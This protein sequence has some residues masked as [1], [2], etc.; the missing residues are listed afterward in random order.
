MRVLTAYADGTRVGYTMNG[1]AAELS[2][3]EIGALAAYYASLPVSRND[4]QVDTASAEHGQTVATNGIMTAGVPSCVSCH[5][6]TGSGI[7]ATFPRI[8][9]QLPDY[10]AARIDLW[11]SGEDRADT[12]VEA[13]MARIAT[14]APPDAMSAAIA[15]FAGLDPA[16]APSTGY[17]SF[18]TNWPAQTYSTKPLPDGIDWSQVDKA[19]AAQQKRLADPT[20]YEHVP[21]DPS[22]IPKS[23]L[24][25]MI[26][27]GKTIFTDTQVLRGTFVGNDL[28]CSN[29]H[30]NAG[31]NPVAAPIWATAVDF[32]VYRGK[33]QH[34][35]TLP[36]RLAGCFKFSMNGTAPPA[37]HEVMVALE[38]YMKWLATGAPSGAVQ[39]ARGYI[40]LP[41]PAQTPDF[42]R[43]ETVYAA[44]CATC[45]AMDGAGLKQGD[46]VVFPPVYQR[47]PTCFAPTASRIRRRTS[48][49]SNTASR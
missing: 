16:A 48:S 38:S 17:T 49:S 7:G 41:T 3:D 33:N 1:I 43:G 40:T 14:N 12:P 4:W 29:C 34:V 31:A 2:S 8:S 10:M 25:D 27:L 23:P 45:H 5:G 39:K 21:P 26:R 37:Q 42:A 20:L 30:M 44:R 36:E 28:A 18:D 46:R 6:Q 9:G 19:Y 11:T 15:Y 47:R 35:N 24:G 13:I 22:D 32:P